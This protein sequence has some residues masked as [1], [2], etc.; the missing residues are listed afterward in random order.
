MEGNRRR[1][2]HTHANSL[3]KTNSIYVCININEYKCNE[4]LKRERH[5]NNINTHHTLANYCIALQSMKGKDEKTR[6]K[7]EPALSSYFEN[8]TKKSGHLSVDLK[9]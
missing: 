4:T 2:S 9:V 3:M 6:N 7:T 1:T 8:G 5:Y